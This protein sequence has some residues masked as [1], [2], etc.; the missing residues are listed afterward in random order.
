MIGRH[1][2]TESQWERIAPL[3][4]GKIGDVGVTAKDNRLFV[5]AVSVSHRDILA[6]PSRPLWPFPSSPYPLQPLGPA[7]RLGVCVQ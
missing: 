6:R 5:E 1:A 4:P 2:L 3:L 7:R